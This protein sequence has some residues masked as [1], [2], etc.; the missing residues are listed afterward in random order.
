MV[1]STLDMF[2]K[3][4]R[5]EMNCIYKE[6]PT[7]TPVTTPETT[8]VRT[9]TTTTATTTTAHSTTT[10]GSG[11]SEFTSIMYT[12]KIIHGLLWWRCVFRIK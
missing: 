8:T 10:S 11:N 6:Q 5:C 3:S 9:T 1:N 7:T 2:R 4:K 12:T